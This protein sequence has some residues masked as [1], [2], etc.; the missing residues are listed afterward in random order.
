MI[1]S[2]TGNLLHARVDALV[3]AVNCAGVMGKGI[4][5][6]FKQA[7]GAMYV[8][9]RQAVKAGDVVLG[10]VHVFTCEGPKLPRYILN[11][12]TK[13]H[14]KSRSQLADIESGLVDL[15][16]QVRH[17]EIASLAI[18]PLGSGYGGLRWAD[19]RPRIVDAFAAL[20]QVRVLLFE[21]RCG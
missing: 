18:P 6:Q 17:L 10:R 1:E 5:L 12:P 8:A 19:V 11:F 14:W 9:Y 15:V 21:P 20:P 7:F 3:N 16:H 4:A 2:T 13:R